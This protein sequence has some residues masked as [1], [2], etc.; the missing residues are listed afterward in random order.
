[1]DVIKAVQSY[2]DRMVR[3]TA[4]TGMKVLLLDPETVRWWV[5]LGRV[6]VVGVVV[7]LVTVG[8]VFAWLWCHV[9][10]LR[11]PAAFVT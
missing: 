2:V 8:L 3:S 10:R 11:V 7:C 4:A 5:C 1:M 9:R 6:C